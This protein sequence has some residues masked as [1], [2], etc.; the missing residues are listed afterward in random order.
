MSDKHHLEDTRSE[1][2]VRSIP[3]FQI[4]QSDNSRLTYNEEEMVTLMVSLKQT[5]L[6]QTIGV[7]EYE[8]GK[9]RILFGNRRFLA[10]KKLGWKKID[11]TVFQTRDYVSEMICNLTENLL[12]ADVALPELGRM[13]HQLIQEGLTLGEI[14][15]RV[16]VP[17]TRV[18]TALEAFNRVPAKFRNKISHGGKKP[19][20][21]SGTTMQEILN[22]KLNNE[23]A[24][25]MFDAATVNDMTKAQVHNVAKFVR[26]GMAPADALR[27]ADNLR[28]VSIR[29]TMKKRTVEELLGRHGGNSIND[30]IVGMLRKI[31]ELDL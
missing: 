25:K 28:E 27:A 19:G 29:F 3:L 23:E 21:V 9:Y 31:P 6:L 10:A 4:E 8:K 26:K 12:Q 2:N 14:S 7:T 5:G 30:I 22:L 20:M 18:K 11:A 17:K 1:L 24:E 13:F 15:A 16:S